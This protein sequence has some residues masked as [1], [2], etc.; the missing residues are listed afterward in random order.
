MFSSRPLQIV[1][2]CSF[3]FATPV[4][5]G[6]DPDTRCRRDLGKGV[7]LLSTEAV[8]RM[9]LCY[10]KQMKGVFPGVDCSDL[11]DPAFP[12]A[13]QVE[14]KRAKLEG[15]AN[16]SCAA[17]STP[18]ALG[19]LV[20]P[21]PCEDTVISDYA[22]VSDCLTCLVKDQAAIAIEDAYGT[23]P[24][25]ATSDQYRC[26]NTVGTEL[27]KY[28]QALVKQQPS[29][30]FSEDK[31]PTGRNC[32]VMDASTDPKAKVEKSLSKLRG[33]IGT[34][35][36][37]AVLSE[38]DSCG[39]NT[40]SEQSCLQANAEAMGDEL[41]S[42][43]YDPAGNDGVYVSE[44]AGS[45]GGAGTID[46]PLDT[47]GGGLTLA[48]STSVPN[49]YI[50]GGNYTESISLRSG[51]NLLGG[52]DASAG[53][54]RTGAATNVFGGTL[55]LSCSGKSGVLIEQ[56]NIEA[57]SNPG[58]GGSSFGIL[59]AGCTSIIVRDSSILAGDG[60]NGSTG[61][62]GSNGSS[63]FTGSNGGNGCE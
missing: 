38:L 18:Q 44:A 52:F 58:V 14:T 47:I 15:F 29:C 7:R 53:W 48:A 12:Y 1:A 56:L 11:D 25:G 39:V 57:S 10:K 30:Q 60:G 46:D 55:A 40:T 5:A 37:T 32:R 54:A 36:L 35:C 27:R 13:I 4:L 42:M 59:L 9:G 17:A 51:I 26:L 33:K 62:A 61:S 19:H 34:K 20:C 31:T 50:D 28:L 2:L 43:V 24:G 16:K 49:V 3:V 22:S 63:G 45:A 6:V 41:F 21:A 8:K 23:V